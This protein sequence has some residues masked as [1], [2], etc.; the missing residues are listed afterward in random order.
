[1]SRRGVVP[2]IAS[3]HPLGSRLPGLY[4]DPEPDGRPN[5]GQ[6]LLAALDDVLAPVFLALDG[7]PA[8]LDPA[9]APSD[10]VDWLGSWL[11]LSFDERWPL[12]R[13]RRLIERATALY[14]LRGTAEGIAQHVEAFAGVR[15]EVT[16][17]GGV[18]WATSPE[19]PLPG[20]ASPRLTVRVPRDGGGEA[21][22]LD[23]I[24]ALV[25]AI[26]PAHVPAEVVLG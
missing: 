18:A 26:R 3:P 7:V 5:L 19:A 6:R 17:S 20:E 8:Y 21:L 14:Q 10:F 16:E 23:R 1:M 24:R 22:D 13:R 9:L 2:E 15:P 25:D 12:D 11:G 4:Q